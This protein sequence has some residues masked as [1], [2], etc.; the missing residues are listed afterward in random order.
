MKRSLF[1]WPISCLLLFQLDSCKEEFPPYTEPSEV[2]KGNLQLLAPD[3][4]RAY[5]PFGGGYFFDNSMAISLVVTNVHDDILQGQA[6]VGGSVYLQSFSE[7]PRAFVVPLTLGDLRTPPVAQGNIALGPGRHA[8]FSL[9]WLPYATDGQV[10][11]AGLPYVQIGSDKIYGPIDFM[12]YADVQL[13]ERVQPVR[14]PSIQ[15]RLTFRV[16]E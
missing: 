7:V 8:Q 5:A 15:F 14:V 13:F 10:V 3:T 11:F 1:H 2:L 6:L 16:T 9:L 12:A 4:V